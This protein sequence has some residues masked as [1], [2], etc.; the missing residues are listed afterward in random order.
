[1]CET[2]DARG[3]WRRDHWAEPDEEPIGER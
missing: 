3:L 2:C 1:V